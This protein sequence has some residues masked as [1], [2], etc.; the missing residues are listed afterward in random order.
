MGSLTVP[1]E[2]STEQIAQILSKFSKQAQ[3]R[4]AHEIF[5]GLR[6]IL[7]GYGLSDRPN[8]VMA[9]KQQGYFTVP[10]AH[11]VHTELALF[12]RDATPGD[13]ELIRQ[14]FENKGM[15]FVESRETDPMPLRRY[16][17]R[18]H[19]RKGYFVFT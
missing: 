10:E 2:L 7:T 4:R 5:K 6:K 18:L 19:T 8:M 3:Y 13:R 15:T 12:I 17:H 1:G 11:K 9:S 16:K 14:L